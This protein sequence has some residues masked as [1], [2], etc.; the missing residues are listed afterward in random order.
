MSGFVRQDLSGGTG[1]DVVIGAGLDRISGGSGDDVLVAQNGGTNDWDAQI[2]IG[3]SGSDLF[4]VEDM[5]SLAPGEYRVEILD[6][7]GL[8]DRLVLDLPDGGSATNLRLT[9]LDDSYVQIECRGV[10]VTT[11]R[12]VNL[13]DLSVGDILLRDTSEDGYDYAQ[14]VA[15]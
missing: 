9:V 7:N 13:T 3:G 10:P 14:I 6:F 1:N 8:E 5:T 2:L 11:L 12:G 15:G 4:V